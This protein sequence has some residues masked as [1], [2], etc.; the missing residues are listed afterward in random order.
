MIS[1]SLDTSDRNWIQTGW[2]KNKQVNEER[3]KRKK[4]RERRGFRPSWI[5]VSGDV[6]LPSLSSTCLC[7]T[8]VSDRFPP[9][10]CKMIPSTSWTDRQ[11]V[12]YAKLHVSF[13][14]D[15]DWVPSRLRLSK[16]HISSG[17]PWSH[18]ASLFPCLHLKS[19]ARSSVNISPARRWKRSHPSLSFQVL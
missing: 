1:T 19:H 18:A 10:G 5:W 6:S 15:S 16:E 12:T 9:Y 4:E 14:K 17:T 11:R 13:P 7:S 8:L 3:K 2:G